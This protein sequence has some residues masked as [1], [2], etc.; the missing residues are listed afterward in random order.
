MGQKKPQPPRSG[1]FAQ[2][3]ALRALDLYPVSG[4]R[5]GGEKARRV[6]RMDSGQFAV[7]TGTCCQRTPE[8]SRVV[9][10][11]HRTTEPPRAHLLVTFLCEQKSD[12]AGG[13]RNNRLTSLATTD[14]RRMTTKAQN[15]TLGPSTGGKGKKCRRQSSKLPR[16][17]GD[18]GKNKRPI[19]AQLDCWV[20]MTT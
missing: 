16:K 13:S 11:L 6:A 17:L 19:R 18:N 8:P 5:V 12:S 9:V 2:R 4:R 7:S 3:D 15:F 20:R 1:G 10:Q 14:P